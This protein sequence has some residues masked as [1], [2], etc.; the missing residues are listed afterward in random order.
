MK[1]THAW[2]AA[3]HVCCTCGTHAC[4]THE[5]IHACCEV[6]VSSICEICATRSRVPHTLVRRR[7][8]RP[9]S[10][11][12]APPAPLHC[13]S[14]WR[15]AWPR[16]P[17]SAPSPSSRKSFNVTPEIGS[18]DPSRSTFPPIPGRIVA[19]STGA[20]AAAQISATAM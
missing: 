8:R 7:P 9:K 13:A 14:C 11:D 18:L 2:R 20:A 12:R 3:E 19:A 10:G 17:P 16:W 5:H 4:G 6:S 15:L 1:R